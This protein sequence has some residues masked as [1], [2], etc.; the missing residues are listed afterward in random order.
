MAYAR[1]QSN[2]NYVKV[3]LY[4]RKGRPVSGH[5]RR[6][7]A[8]KLREVGAA[9][10]KRAEERRKKLEQEYEALRESDPVLSLHVYGPGIR[11]GSGED[12]V[13]VYHG[14]I[15][16]EE[17]YDVASNASREIDEVAEQIARE[18]GYHPV[19]AWRGYYLT[20]DAVGDLV[21][22]LD[23]WVSPMGHSGASETEHQVPLEE[24]MKGWKTHQPPVRVYTAFTPT[25]NV[26]S[27]GMDMYVH[28][29]D[30]PA[31]KTYLQSKQVEPADVPGGY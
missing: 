14:K 19:D 25:S 4:R 21:K 31:F 20:P 26:F 13:Y 5:Y 23:T 27:V 11:T 2:Q 30:V 24:I 12:Y 22:V 18:T 28:K 7:D 3:P 8:A 6:F 9:N 29:K 16:G 15:G 17:V 10:V 1:K